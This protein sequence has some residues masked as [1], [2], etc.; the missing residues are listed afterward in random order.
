M[1]V[2]EAF[3]NIVTAH[4]TYFRGLP[5]EQRAIQQSLEVVAEALKPTTALQAAKEK[6]EPD[7][8]KKK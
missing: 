5:V 6:K 2:Q 8:N 4:E 1:N 3:N 7:G